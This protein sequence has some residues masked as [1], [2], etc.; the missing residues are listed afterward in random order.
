MPRSQ[1]KTSSRQSCRRSGLLGETTRGR[2]NSLALQGMV[3]KNTEAQ[4]FGSKFAPTDVE[5]VP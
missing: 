3:T 2:L 5:L 1:K 4:A